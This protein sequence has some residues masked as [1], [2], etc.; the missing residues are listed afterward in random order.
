MSGIPEQI[1][2][3]LEKNEE[4]TALE[5]SQALECTPANIRYHLS[6]LEQRGL[7][8]L[9]IQQA[10]QTRGRP[11]HHYC[12]TTAAQEHNLVKLAGALLSA[13]AL[14]AERSDNHNLAQAACLLAG[15]PAPARMHL[16][17]RLNYAVRRLQELKYLPRWEAYSSGPRLYLVHCPYSALFPEHARILCRFD[18]LLLAAL[19]GTAVKQITE[20]AAH[21]CIFSVG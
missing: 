2:A 1:C 6:R 20:P 10:G 18:A 13:L 3:Y 16:T 14:E 17:Q 12:L 11:V 7:V 8:Q 5:L 9:S 21:P 15:T 19:L 4:A